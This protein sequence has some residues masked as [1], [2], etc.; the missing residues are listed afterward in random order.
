MVSRRRALGLGLA[1]V[2]GVSVAA[3]GSGSDSG[4]ASGGGSWE[5][6]D[7]RGKRI[8]LKQRPQRIVAY[9]GVIGA[10]NDYGVHFTG[11]YGPHSPVDGKL[12]PQSGDANFA[13]IRSVGEKYGDFDIEKLLALRPD[14][15]LETSFLPNKSFYITPEVL[16]K[17]EQAVP[18]A[19]ID[20]SA[21]TNTLQI[22]DNM[23]KLA[24]SLGGD[25][26]S[27]AA[28]QARSRF[29]KASAA[30]KENAKANPLRVLMVS[31]SP[32]KLFVTHPKEQDNSRY[33]QDL[34]VNFVDPP[35][36]QK[37]EVFTELS[38][39]QVGRYPAD[40][41]LYDSRPQAMKIEELK[42]VPTF[43]TLPA[44]KAGNVAPWNPE[45]PFSHLQL[46]KNLEPIAEWQRTFKPVAV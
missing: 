28:K 32:D 34:G 39:E 22:L 44:V 40:V 31:G 13:N 3:C 36:T 17:V 41:I 46:A 27:D 33:V 12:N 29:D 43:A 8:S 2:A 6:T 16:P 9:S 45:I 25:P 19:L 30:I 7:A 42:K 20:T 35:Y 10:L 26:D 38:W 1:A 15:V 11:V 37:G 21:R 18:V 14:I 23:T 5:Y 24:R 4:P